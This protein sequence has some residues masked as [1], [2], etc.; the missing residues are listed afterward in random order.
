MRR[1]NHERFDSYC[2]RST[3]VARLDEFWL[4]LSD[5]LLL[6]YHGRLGGQRNASSLVSTIVWLLCQLR[7]YLLFL[8]LKS[9]SSSGNSCVSKYLIRC[10]ILVSPTHCS[11]PIS[12]KSGKLG[13]GLSS[14]SIGKLFLIL[15]PFESSVVCNYF[16]MMVCLIDA[17][18]LDT[19]YKS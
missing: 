19:F 9:F 17:K 3:F 10:C 15:Q 2:A 18:M 8:A 13:S 14:K 4:F 5:I 6:S 1:C 16:E 12:S 7:S 11:W